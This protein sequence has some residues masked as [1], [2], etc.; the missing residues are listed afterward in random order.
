MTVL[1][2]LDAA[3]HYL[4]ILCGQHDPV[5]CFQCFDDSTAKRPQLAW[6]TTSKLSILTQR[7][8]AA[9]ADRAGVFVTINGTDGRGRKIEN[10]T[11]LRALFVDCDGTRELPTEWPLQPS[12]VV[13]RG[14]RHW[15]AYWCLVADQALT[16]FTQ[17]QKQMAT[18]WGTDLGVSDLP[19]VMR[20]PGFVHHKGEPTAVR[21]VSSC[22]TRYSIDQVL[23]AHPAEVID[24]TARRVDVPHG[25]SRGHKLNTDAEEMFWRWA[26]KVEI[27]KGGAV[28]KGRDTSC[29]YIACEG[30]GRFREGKISMACVHA[31]V[32]DY[33]Q[34]AGLPNP[35]ADA[36]RTI[37][38]AEA[39]QFIKTHEA[40]GGSHHQ[41]NTSDR[42]QL[43]LSSAEDLFGGGGGG[44]DE[45]PAGADAG[46][47]GDDRPRRRVQEAYGDLDVGMLERRWRI[48][49]DG[50]WPV[51][52]NSKEK[53]YQAKENKRV[54][55]LPIWVEQ[56]GKDVA[57]GG[58]Y[59]LVAW[60]TPKGIIR[61]QWLSES[62]LKT[63][64]ALIAL[65]DGPVAKRR[66]EDCA[67]WLTAARSAVTRASIEVTSR[68]G[69]CGINGGR[70]WVW[71]G[72][73]GAAELQ[74]IGGELPHHGTIEG[75]KAGLDHLVKIT[76]DD[77][78]TA[79]TV[80]AMSIASPWS[81]LMSSR[82]PVI[83][84]LAPSSTGKGASLT[85]ALSPW[86]D[87]EQFTLPASSTAKGI[88][89]LGVEFPDS[90]LFLDELQE[91]VE[92]DQNAAAGALYFLANGQRRRTSNKEQKSAG[93]ERRHGVSFYAA[94]AVVLSGQNVGVNY[95][96][97]ELDG[98]P[99][100]DEE[101][102]KILQAA[103]RH[104]GVLVGPIAAHLAKKTVPQWCEELTAKAAAIRKE[105]AGLKGDDPE[106]LALLQLGYE[107]LKA[108]IGVDWEIDKHIAW[109][110]ARIAKQRAAV[111]DRET[112]C[113]YQV[114]SSVLNQQWM[115]WPE[116]PSKGPTL[117]MSITVAGVPMAWRDWR[118]DGPTKGLDVNAQHRDIVPI[119]RDAGGET[120][121]LKAWHDRGWI[122]RQ[123]SHL[124][125]RRTGGG[126][127]VRFTAQAL[128]MF[129]D[130]PQRVPAATAPER[131]APTTSDEEPPF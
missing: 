115:S 83:G 16:R 22:E 59:W 118:V 69:W 41:D 86:G 23:T 54:T 56:H 18:F 96:V 66:C 38:S 101:T 88:Q 49:V 74:Y 90:P 75:W 106:A 102:A 122:V 116:D 52:W 100:P 103:S 87:P 21:I 53:E 2:D 67:V 7:L 27:S 68:I 114:M 104:T 50:V 12:L 25:T 71:P 108:T 78:W 79:L 58:S 3:H 120:R 94:E 33:A 39:K 62:D 42:M 9:N 13:Q 29:F 99:C 34:R 95:R 81:R 98:P 47:E 64:Q 31:V 20:V 123:G 48:T 28:G 17:A 93:G 105:Y 45:P 112:V 4:A 10:V 91:L 32:L 8:S 73:A 51:E 89:D 131:P 107:T 1:L 57:S 97:I 70:R 24:P 11:A 40:A 35:Q 19:R 110:V 111:Q 121:V 30:V 77:Q 117:K 15:H 124:R 14:P 26:S 55:D 43:P 44:D 36:E 119:F 76:A 61:R 84:L 63:G 37:K 125:C 113:L 46:D 126:Y 129:D 72:V 65:P 80:V 5:V 109:L 82:N 127:V 128:A 60:K 85:F 6:N 130:G 92:R